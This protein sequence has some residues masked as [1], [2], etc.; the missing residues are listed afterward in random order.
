MHG[1]FPEPFYMK[2]QSDVWR[3]VHVSHNQKCSKMPVFM[4]EFGT[5]MLVRVALIHAFPVAQYRV[6]SFYFLLP[7]AIA[8]C[9]LHLL[10]PFTHP[11]N[12]WFQKYKTAGFRAHI[13]WTLNRQVWSQQMTSHRHTPTD[14]FQDCFH[15]SGFN[16]PSTASHC[17]SLQTGFKKI[18]YF[19][20]NILSGLDCSHQGNQ[21]IESWMLW[22]YGI[23]CAVLTTR[24]VYYLH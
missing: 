6:F 14:C 16:H 5:V 1:L 17:W 3:D 19:P 21:S 2:A 9:C 8:S 24:T 23:I 4:R 20:Q 18:Q 15:I 7:A 22:C 11:H 10:R 12:L 13:S